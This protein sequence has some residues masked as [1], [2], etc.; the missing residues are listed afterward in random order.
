MANPALSAQ[1]TLQQDA[2]SIRMNGG[3][4]AVVYGPGIQESE[5]LF[6]D[7]KVFLK[8][9]RL[10]GESTIIELDIE[11]KNI[12][13][14]VHSYDLH[15]V[16]GEFQHV[17]FY[18]LDMNQEVTTHIPLTFIGNAPAVKE[19]S[20]ILVTSKSELAVKCLPKDLVHD[21]EVDISSLAE[22]HD[23]ICIKDISLPEGI[24]VLD[25][26]SDTVISATA[27]K[28]EEE[29]PDEEEDIEGEGEEGEASGEEGAESGE[30][31]EEATEE[32]KEK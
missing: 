12:P 9:F 19:K 10:T 23:H 32:K 4:P 5:K 7:Y 11:G 29:E 6:L 21:I 3:I 25:E 1:K 20:A 13:V 17:D 30:K 8:L 14:L 22:Y 26:L 16:S 24:T 15:P 18:A 2:K 28:L 27:P 31:Q